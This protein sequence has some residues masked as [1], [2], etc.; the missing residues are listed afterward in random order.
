MSDEL[1]DLIRFG[2]AGA[3]GR[4]QKLAFIREGLDTGK[5][6]NQPPYA[7]DVSFLDGHPNVSYGPSFDHLTGRGTTAS[8]WESSAP[9]WGPSSSWESSAPAWD[10][11]ESASG[12]T[13]STGVNQYQFSSSG[14]RQAT[15]K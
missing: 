4:A 7:H 9:A 13:S 8:S 10:P 1:C 5:L 11:S 12:A 6:D 15:V 14:S 3:R 2:R